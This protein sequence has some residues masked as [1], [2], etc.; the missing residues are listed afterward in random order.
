MENLTAR[1]GFSCACQACALANVVAPF[2]SRPKLRV[3]C[4]CTVS[5]HGLLFVFVDT[6]VSMAKAMRRASA[7]VPENKKDKFK[8]V[9]M[10]IKMS[11]LS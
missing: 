8:E 11:C 4:N 2:A 7:F 9:S 3:C 1:L 6:S 5:G 10:S